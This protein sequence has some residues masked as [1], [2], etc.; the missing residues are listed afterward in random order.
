MD[1]K[2]TFFRK[3]KKGY[4][5]TKEDILRELPF[6]LFITIL[7]IEGKYIKNIFEDALKN[8]HTKS[9]NFPQVSN[10]INLWF[11]RKKSIGERVI[12]ITINGNEIQKDKIYKIVTTNYLANGGDSFSTFKFKKLS[13]NEMKDKFIFNY[14]I[15]YLRENKKKITN[16]IE[17]RT[18]CVD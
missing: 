7:E 1:E 12:K 4:E 16:R 9:G 10:E 6:P 18:I 17:G 5:I 11:S 14:M 2:F 3:Y 15:D 13:S 8:A